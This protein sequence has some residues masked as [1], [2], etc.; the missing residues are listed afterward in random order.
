MKYMLTAVQ[1]QPEPHQ[2]LGGLEVITFEIHNLT[3]LAG[4]S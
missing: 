2:R 3:W 4:T 1:R